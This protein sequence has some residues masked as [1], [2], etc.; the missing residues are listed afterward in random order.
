[1]LR[2]SSNGLCLLKFYFDLCY[3]DYTEC[4][5]EDTD[6][7]VLWYYVVEE[8]GVAGGNSRPWTGDHYPANRA[9]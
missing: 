4:V 8:T 2:S 7:G 5:L 9:R 6:V 3:I 1:M